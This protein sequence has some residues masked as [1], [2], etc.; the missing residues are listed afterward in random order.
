MVAPSLNLRGL[1]SSHGFFSRVL[2]PR[3]KKNQVWGSGKS[4]VGLYF[5]SESVVSGRYIWVN[6]NDLT[7]LPNPGNH[8]FYFRE[9]IPFYGR[10][11]QVSELLNIC[12]EYMK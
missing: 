9:I 6:Y 5:P 12:P 8:G 2:K 1:L 11:I 10:K 3:A 7:V 4:Y